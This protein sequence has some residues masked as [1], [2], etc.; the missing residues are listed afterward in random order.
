[1]QGWIEGFQESI[2]FIEQNLT[3][4][5][6]IENIASKAALSTFYYQRIFGALCGMTAGEYIRARRMSL[7]V[8]ELNRKDVK[9]IDIAISRWRVELCW[10]IVLLK[11]LRLLLSE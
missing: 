7:A 10:I 6:D 1:M 11:R 3:E 9:V 8:Q 2:D 4:E 5:L